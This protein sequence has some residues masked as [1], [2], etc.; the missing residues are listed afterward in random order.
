MRRTMFK[1]RYYIFLMLI[2][3]NLFACGISEGDNLSNSQQ[4][5][6]DK[7]T[8]T[9]DTVLIEDTQASLSEQT[10]K[11]DNPLSYQV[12]VNKQFFL[13]S[14]FQPDDLRI[15]NVSDASKNPNSTIMLRERA[16]EMAE[17]MFREAQL[18]NLEILLVSGFRSFE[19]QNR[20]YDDY[21]ARYGEKEAN[22][23]S[24]QPG[25]SEHQTGLAMDLSTS[26]L[27]GG[28]SEEFSKTP[29]G[30]WL[31]ANA[32]R[33]G[34][35]I[36]YPEGREEETGYMYEPWHFRYVGL[37]SAKIINQNNWIFEEYFVQ[38]MGDGLPD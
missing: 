1:K 14:D 9:E 31:R 3:S 2:V 24:A 21:V 6:P 20:L 8:E 29:E 16:A 18:E 34:F 32:H 13:P 37:A 27:G 19:R 30:E 15:L 17:Q 4:W 38:V 26:A 7:L 10:Q 35:I 28:I 25:H 22:R 36:R 5:V 11:I 12:L 23:F 33:F